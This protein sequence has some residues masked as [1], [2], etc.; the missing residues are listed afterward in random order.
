[1]K[2]PAPNRRL[3]LNLRTGLELS[4]GQSI[5]P[6]TM[7]AAV[8]RATELIGSMRHVLWVGEAIRPLVRRIVA[9]GD[10]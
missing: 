6:E 5:D 8:A 3:G 1:M 9:S 4:V 10:S 2:R 7:P